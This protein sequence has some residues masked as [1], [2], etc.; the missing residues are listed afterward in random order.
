MNEKQNR[1]GFIILSIGALFMVLVSALQILSRITNFNV[2]VIR[3]IH[4]IIEIIRNFLNKGHL[5]FMFLFLAGIFFLTTS[6]FKK[7][8]G[9][10]MKIASIVLVLTY[11][12]YIIFY[13]SKS[14]D[15]LFILDLFQTFMV[16]FCV[17][18]II[19][20]LMFESR[21]NYGVLLLAAFILQ[22]FKLDLPTFSNG[23]LFVI[24]QDV[25][26]IFFMD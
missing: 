9:T 11:L 6:T 18:F 15:T 3:D 24:I 14:N 12:L 7:T 20:L 23:E 5:F 2:L 1:V 26:Y 16:I 4:S 17:A 21:I 13:Y 19:F 25:F 22:V 8:V 10:I